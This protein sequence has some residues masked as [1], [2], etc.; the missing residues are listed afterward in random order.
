MGLIFAVNLPY[1]LMP[2]TR[3]VV[4]DRPVYVVTFYTDIFQY[5]IEP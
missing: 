5:T 3:F 4:L 2:A 1:H